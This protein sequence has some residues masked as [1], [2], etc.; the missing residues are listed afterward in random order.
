MNKN[1]YLNYNKINNQNKFVDFLHLDIS[2]DK[3]SIT[4]DEVEKYKKIS[5]KFFCG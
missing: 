2:D 1:I 5:K 4:I 3:N